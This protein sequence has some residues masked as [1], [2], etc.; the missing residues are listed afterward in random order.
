MTALT[1]N[2]N[3]VGAEADNKIIRHTGNYQTHLV[4]I[5][6][7]LPVISSQQ[8]TFDM[9]SLS[10]A[11]KD[12]PHCMVP[13]QLGSNTLRIL[14]LSFRYCRHQPNYKPRIQHTGTAS[15]GDE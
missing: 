10:A 12:I 8:E 3:F 5:N 13:G 14:R 15:Q 4:L 9:F 1:W 11:S 6:N 7:L 2:T